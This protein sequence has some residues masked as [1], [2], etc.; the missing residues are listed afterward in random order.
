MINQQNGI[1]QTPVYE[2]Q[3]SSLA[4]NINLIKDLDCKYDIQK[5]IFTLI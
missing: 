5:K 2:N 4:S 3:Y 1:C